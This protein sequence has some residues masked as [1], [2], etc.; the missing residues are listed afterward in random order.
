MDTDPSRFF[1]LKST[2]GRARRGTLTLAR[3]AVQTPVFMPVGTQASVKA[4]DP[5]DLN[6]IG[7]QI[8]LANTYHLMLRPG[9][10]L[11]EHLGGVS[12]FMRWDRPL[13]TDS[14]GF[15]VFSLARNRTVTDEGVAFRSHI[16]GS[17]HI[18][19]PER[20]IT[21]QYQFG[22]DIT[23]ALDVLAGFGADEAEQTRAMELTH[24]WL[25]RNVARF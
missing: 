13:L 21:L 11:L 10:D 12:H 6:A 18:L 15:Q 23:M 1:T 5:A 3:G 20:A 17:L 9:A 2:D 8:I 22:S 14:G 7:T 25:P 24:R 4:L 19:T 16:D